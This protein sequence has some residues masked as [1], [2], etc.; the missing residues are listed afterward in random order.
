APRPDWQRAPGVQNQYST[1][2]RQVPDVAASGDT[3]SGW[4]IVVQRNKEQWGGT[5]AATPFWAAS[6]L[7]TRQF[8]QR[9][10][11]ARLGFLAPALYRLARTPQPYPPFHD[12][13]RG[14][15][16]FYEATPGWDYSTGLGSP[17]VYNLARDL[18]AALRR[19]P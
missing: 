11:V 3:D 12:I 19:R 4:M 13:T 18:V 9:H 16:R 15:N 6:M 7:L 1:G 10:G 14:A 17:D 8:A 2:A 5:S